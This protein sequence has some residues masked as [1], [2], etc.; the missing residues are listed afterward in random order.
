M[1]HH[2]LS[3]S[4]IVFLF[5]KF[6]FYGNGMTIPNNDDIVEGG[7]SSTNHILELW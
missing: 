5:E 1:G 6:Q 7:G 4:Q 3:T 2:F